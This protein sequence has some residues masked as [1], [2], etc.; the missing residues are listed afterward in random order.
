MRTRIFLLMT[1]FFTLQTSFAAATD[2]EKHLFDNG[3]DFTLPYR[4]YQPKAI[5]SSHR[6]PLIIFLHGAGD[7]GTNN[8]SQLANFP[9]HFLDSANSIRYPCYVLAPQCTEASPWSWF[10]DY[11]AVNTLPTPTKSTAQ[12]LALI[13]TLLNSDTL[14]IDRNRLYI[15]GFSLGGEGA[16][17][18]ITRAPDLFSAAVPVCGIA[19]TAKAGL[20]ANT[21][22]WI[23]HGDRDD[24]NS[25]TYS[26]IIVQALTNIGKPP[27]YT[28]YAGMGH[29]VWSKAFKEPDLLPWLFSKTKLSVALRGNSGNARTKDIFSINVRNNSIGVSWNGNEGP[30]LVELF[31]LDGKRLFKITIHS[32]INQS[33]INT[34]NTVFPENFSCIIRCSKRGRLLCAEFLHNLPGR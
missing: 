31:S 6:Y 21:P 9:Y 33:V 11:P 14:F 10:P 24:V 2:F 27:K 3:A 25:V 8:T 32:G 26:R 20:M 15:V 7:W 18:I 34:G 29:S 19:D 28:E 30:D 23:F 5:E 22:L 13:D 1:F 4:F 12:V 17:D 16:F